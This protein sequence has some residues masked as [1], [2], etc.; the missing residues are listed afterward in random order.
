MVFA[1]NSS[2]SCAPQQNADTQMERKA[3]KGKHNWLKLQKCGTNKLTKNPHMGGQAPVNGPTPNSSFAIL[4]K[5]L[6]HSAE[7]G[8][9]I[10]SPRLLTASSPRSRSITCSFG[11]AWLLD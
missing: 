10:V 3:H 8:S 4:A 11:L 6:E 1:Q 5:Y 2:P 7:D 9:P